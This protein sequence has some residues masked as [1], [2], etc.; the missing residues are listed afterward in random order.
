[1]KYLEIL[2]FEKKEV[3]QRINISSISERRI[4]KLE[5][6]MNINLN[7]NEYYTRQIESEEDLKI[8]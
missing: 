2:C 5:N 6:G 8:F 4:K 3:H 1:M 7:H